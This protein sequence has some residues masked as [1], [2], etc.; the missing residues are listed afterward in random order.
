MIKVK[1]F[2]SKSGWWWCIIGIDNVKKGMSNNDWCQSLLCVWDLFFRYWV[3]V[4]KKIPTYTLLLKLVS[5]SL[6]SK[7]YMMWNQFKVLGGWGLQRPVVPLLAEMTY[8]IVIEQA[9]LALN[10]IHCITCHLRYDRYWSFFWCNCPQ[11]CCN[12]PIKQLDSSDR[13]YQNLFRSGRAFKSLQSSSIKMTMW[14]PFISSP[15]MVYPIWH[16]NCQ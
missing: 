9:I 10:M 8:H 6:E 16:S 12:M 4:K 5:L 11:N 14:C 15:W 7:V 1:A 13:F 3:P 2:R